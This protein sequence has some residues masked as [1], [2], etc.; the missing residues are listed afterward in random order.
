MKDVRRHGKSECEGRPKG[1]TS[2][3]LE[4]SRRNSVGQTFSFYHGGY[5]LLVCLQEK[6][7]STGNSSQNSL[8]V[9][10]SVRLGGQDL[11]ADEKETKTLRG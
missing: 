7:G 5:E 2:I 6:E 3:A 10:L 9:C 1:G 8:S 4:H 11:V